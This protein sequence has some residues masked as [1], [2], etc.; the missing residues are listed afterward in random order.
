MDFATKLKKLRTD[1]GISQTKL[2]ELSGVPV[3][4]LRDY[5]QGKRRRDPG[6]S[7]V[8]RLCRVLSAPLDSFADCFKDRRS[9]RKK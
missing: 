7:L 9:A 1:A 3:A 8:V 4:T 6:Y 2:A 5:E